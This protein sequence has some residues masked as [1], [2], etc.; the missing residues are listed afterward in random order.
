MHE[1][2]CSKCGKETLWMTIECTGKIDT[3]ECSV[4]KD[5]HTHS[6][7]FGETMS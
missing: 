7:N 4:C 3:C 2:Y 6:C 5:K 1:D